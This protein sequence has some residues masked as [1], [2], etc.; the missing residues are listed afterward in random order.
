MSFFDMDNDFKVEAEAIEVPVVI[1]E[2]NIQKVYL[3]GD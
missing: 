1:D 2:I 3:L